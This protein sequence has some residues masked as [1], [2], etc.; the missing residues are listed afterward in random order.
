[1]QFPHV[2]TLSSFIFLL[3]LS[4]A[5][6]A[7]AQ[8]S[9]S[10]EQ[11]S[12]SPSEP[13]NFDVTSKVSVEEVAPDSAIQNR[14]ADILQTTEWFENIEVEVR[15]SVAFLYGTTPDDERKEWAGQI[16]RKMEGV[17]VVVNKI[18]VIKTVNISEAL[19]VV[20]KS[21]SGLWQD[22]LAR[23]PLIVAGLL[24]LV[25]TGLFNQ[26]AGMIL[27]RFIKR[28][29]LRTGLKDLIKQLT[30]IGIW[31]IGLL[32]TAVIVFPGM[33]P[34]KA[35]TVLGLGSVAIG[36][37][38]KDIFENFFAGILILW[39][40]PFDRGD[41]IEAGEIEGQIEEITIR[42]TKL[43]QVDGKL[44]V[45]PNAMLFKSPVN[46]LT[47]RPFRR[48]TIM[49]GVAYDTD[50]RKAHD[51]LKNAVQNC[52]S[53]SPDQ[54]IEIFA[55]EFADSSINFEITW[56]TGA[57]PLEIRKS[58]HEVVNAVKHDLNQ[59]GIEIPF[60]QRTLRLP[61]PILMLPADKV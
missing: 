57:K 49:C 2:K 1:M 48:T 34:A 4:S 59:A 7:I 45:V 30:T 11:S 39:K 60:P 43:R 22:F 20:S 9:E 21:I 12:N 28:S 19:D 40:Y 61:E 29:R 17:A 52:G 15:D 8:Q 14:L 26:L 41:F 55:R 18:E 44:V 33:T 13:S 27:S 53:V 31:I 50:L 51:V 42:M 54:P 37:A 58:E 56:W 32:L 46:V 35:L 16:A 3:I 36:F 23:S 25:A 47:N 38:F 10:K 5:V 6:P 24:A